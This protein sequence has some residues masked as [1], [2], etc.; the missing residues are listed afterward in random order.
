MAGNGWK[1]VLNMTRLVIK[2]LNCTTDFQILLK[3]LGTH[4]LCKPEIKTARHLQ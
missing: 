2:L 1:F 4:R 3:E